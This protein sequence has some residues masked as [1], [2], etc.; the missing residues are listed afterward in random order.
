MGRLFARWTDLTENLSLTYFLVK[1]SRKSSLAL[2]R[3][4]VVEGPVVE[5]ELG[6]ALVPGFGC[7]GT[8]LTDGHD[9]IDRAQ[10]FKQ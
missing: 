3:F 2:G 8:Q 5:V 1:P 10:L 4:E 9:L 7:F 6:E